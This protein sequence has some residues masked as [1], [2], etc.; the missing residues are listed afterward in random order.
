MQSRTKLKSASLAVMLLMLASP[1]VLA[2]G[3]TAAANVTVLEPA[4]QMPGLQRSRILR[5]YLPPDYQSSNDSYPVLYMHDA[6]NLFDA[7]T[8]YAGEW[9]VDESLNQLAQQGLKLIVVGIDNGGEFRNQELLPY[10]GPPIGQAQGDQYLQFLVTV[11]KPYID[12]HYR[13]KADAANTGIMGS[14]MGGLISHYALLKYPQVFGRYGLFS[15]SYWAVGANVQ[16]FSQQLPLPGQRLYFYMGLQEGGSMV[17]DIER[18][19]H[20]LVAKGMTAQQ[21]QYRLVEGADH[22]E[23]AWAAEFSRAVLWLYQGK[24]L[25]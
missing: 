23:A 1:G 13:T 4:F 2:K 6:Q 3:S 12:Q 11:V 10:S 17:P 21:A 8:S 5:L 24:V 14:S 25:P 16:Q 15:P 7:S 19:V 22:N 18:L 9:R 20:K